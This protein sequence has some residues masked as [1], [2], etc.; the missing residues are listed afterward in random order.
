M[1]AH[2]A[3]ERLQA[4]LSQSRRALGARSPTDFARI[5]LRSHCSLPLS[6]MHRELFQALADLVN[7]R[8]GRL[9]VAAPRGHAKSTIVSLAF[10]LWCVLYEKEKFVVLVSATKD[11]AISL[12][13]DVKDELT[14]NAFLLTDFPEACRPEGASAQV[15]PWRNAR[16]Q[17]PNGAMIVTYGAGQ[18]LR[19]TKHGPNRPGLII[20][21]DI[22]SPEGVLAEEQRD[23][24]DTWFTK[25]LI[26]AGRPGTN[27][28]VVGT[29]LHHDSLLSNLTNSN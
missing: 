29:V 23:K 20:V 16:I 19:G 11:Q 18:G 15:K 8:G 24:L 28:I 27:V 10:I 22:E 6:R 14:K 3:S 21:D 7:S 5:Y 9:A 4:T 13:K 17:L 26:H 12:L 25:T 2:N 1:S